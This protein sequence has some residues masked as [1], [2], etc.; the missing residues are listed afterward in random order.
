[1]SPSSGLKRNFIKKYNELTK[2]PM[3]DT[4]GSTQLLPT[5]W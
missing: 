3:V 1:M 4:E 2:E 5:N